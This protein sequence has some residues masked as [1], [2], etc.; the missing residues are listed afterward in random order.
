MRREREGEET[1]MARRVGNEAGEHCYGVAIRRVLEGF[2]EPILGVLFLHQ[3]LLRERVL[4][5]GGQIG[6]AHV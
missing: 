3:S 5:K 2:V 4:W 1:E 6:R